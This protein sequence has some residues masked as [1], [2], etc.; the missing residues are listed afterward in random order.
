VLVVGGN[1]P[2][3]P[4]KIVAMKSFAEW[5]LTQN[6]SWQTLFAEWKLAQNESWQ[7]L[8]AEWICRHF[9]QNENWRKMKDDRHFL[10]N[11]NWRKIKVGRH[12]LQN[13]SLPTLFRMTIFKTLSQI[14][15]FIFRNETIMDTSKSDFPPYDPDH[16]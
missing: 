16:P 9:L 7:T 2:H 12:F 3:P 4:D 6:E 1:S 15:D 8:F 10:Q 11:E 5:K 14:C 13:E